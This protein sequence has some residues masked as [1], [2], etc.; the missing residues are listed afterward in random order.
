MIELDLEDYVARVLAGEGEPR[1]GD[2]AQQALAITVR[3]F[4]AAN[5]GRH[6]REGYD[7]CDTTHCQVFRAAHR[8]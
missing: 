6:R 3:T 1:A 4:A 2:A 7:F 8:R 5:R